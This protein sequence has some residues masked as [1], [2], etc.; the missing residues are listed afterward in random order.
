[1]LITMM[2]EH[3]FL[4]RRHILYER[5]FTYGE[6]TSIAFPFEVKGVHGHVM[7]VHE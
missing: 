6:R 5:D 3:N 7:Y 2:T 1:M 4:L